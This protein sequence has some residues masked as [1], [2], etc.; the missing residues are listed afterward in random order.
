MS[1]QVASAWSGSLAEFVTTRSPFEPLIFLFPRPGARCLFSLSARQLSCEPRREPCCAGS[2]RFQPVGA[3]HDELRTTH[4]K[5]QALF[6]KAHMKGAKGLHSGFRS[7]ASASAVG[8]RARQFVPMRHLGWVWLCLFLASRIG[9][10]DSE[11]RTDGVFAAL[12]PYADACFAAAIGQD[13]LKLDSNAAAVF[14]QPLD[15]SFVACNPAASRPTAVSAARTRP[16]F[17]GIVQ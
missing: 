7:S 5:R 17:S 4:E 15:R 13:M 2:H 1:T 10:C 3:D 12:A 6:A 8:F 14:L 9:Q 16:P 11:D